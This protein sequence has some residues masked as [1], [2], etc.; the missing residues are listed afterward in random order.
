MGRDRGSEF[1]HDDTRRAVGD[2]HCGLQAGSGGEHYGE[3]CDHRVAGTGH[4]E[5]LGLAGHGRDRCGFALG[6]QSHSMFAAGKEQRLEAELVAQS[7]G[8]PLEVLLV[9][10]GADHPAEL[11]EV[12]GD[13]V[14]ALVARI[15]VT[16]RIG[17][18]APAGL[19][20]RAHHLRDVR[21]APFAVVGENHRVAFG[22]RALEFL[23]LG[24]EHLARRGLLEI[25]AQELLLA[26][27]D[28][29]LLRR[30]ELAI[31]VQARLDAFLLD[32]LLELRARLVAPHHRE[33][34]CVRAERLA[35]PRHVG[36]AAEPLLLAPDQHH[37]HRRLGGDPRHLAEPVAV[38]HH[39]AHH[40][41]P[42]L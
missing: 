21:E 16:L 17:E 6:K 28:A 23:E 29:Q 22:E 1:T 19:A 33:Q 14:H 2:A 25:D 38:E 11:V 42:R 37:R 35:V 36:R 40:Q 32:Q 10:P 24:R 12:R 18:H 5:H 20:R 31:A 3:G 34:A 39:V 30:V 41:D 9:L 8:A 27:D 13:D 7:L 4:V 15:V 26:A